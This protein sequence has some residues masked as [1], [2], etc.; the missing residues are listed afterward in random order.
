M[1][2]SWYVQKATDSRL[3]PMKGSGLK[4]K[5]APFRQTQFDLAP[6]DFVADKSY[7]LRAVGD[8][9][10]VKIWNNQR[11][12]SYDNVSDLIFGADCSWKYC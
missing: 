6:K 4:E 10:V 9:S 11:I 12:D 8:L 2:E 5:L 7:R 3:E 1:V